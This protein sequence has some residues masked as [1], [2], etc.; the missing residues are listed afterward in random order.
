MSLWTLTGFLN[1]SEAGKLVLSDLSVPELQVTLSHLSFSMHWF[2]VS[3][4]VGWWPR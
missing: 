4:F 3:G 1:W 2:H